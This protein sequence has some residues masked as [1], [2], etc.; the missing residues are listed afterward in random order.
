[1]DGFDPDL[2]VPVG[3]CASR[4]HKVG[5]RD[6]VKEEDL[7]GDLTETATPRHGIGLIELLRDFA[8]K[9]LKYKRNDSLSVEFPILPRSDR[10]FLASVFGAVPTAAQKII[11]R[12]FANVAAIT[13][14]RPKIE[15]FVELLGPQRVFPRRLS[16]WALEKKP[17]R[18]ATL[19]VC[20]ATSA[21]DIIDYWNLRAAG[22]YVI[23]IPIQGKGGL[24]EQLS[25]RSYELSDLS[26]LADATQQLYLQLP[27]YYDWSEAEWKKRKIKKEPS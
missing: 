12:Q 3:K 25:E 23:P 22:Y 16:V 21:Q 11:D 15:N 27:D 9:E 7:I 5:N 2:A 1:M 19:F 17:L 13:K 24:F 8:D 14:V 4:P 26:K 6:V 20:D 10:L 18:D